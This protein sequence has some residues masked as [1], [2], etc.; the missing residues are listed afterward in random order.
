[1]TAATMTRSTGRRRD[2]AALAIE[3][4]PA[5]VLR[6][7]QLDG[8]ATLPASDRSAARARAARGEVPADSRHPDL[9]EL[10]P[11]TPALAAE[12]RAILEAELARLTRTRRD[13]SDG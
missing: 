10:A 6:R 13:R 11:I 7:L 9:P 12:H 4:F 8:Y 3:A 2:L 5:A 1:M